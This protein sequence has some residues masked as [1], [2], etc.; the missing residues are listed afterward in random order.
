MEIENGTE[1]Y[2]VAAGGIRVF[3]RRGREAIN[4][5]ASLEGFLGLHVYDKWHTLWMFDTV[6][7]AK[8]ARNLM[9]GKGIRCGKNIGRFV[10][11]DECCVADDVWAETNGERKGDL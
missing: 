10:M 11:R 4:Y 7:H 6:N 1:M 8:S 9:V 3:S 2:S 5:V